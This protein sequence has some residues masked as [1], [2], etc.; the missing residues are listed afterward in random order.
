MQPPRAIGEASL[1]NRNDAPS[2]HSMF[3][4]LQKKLATDLQ[5][6]R[7]VI[8]HGPTL[9]DVSEFQWIEM[10]RNLPQRYAVTK[11]FV[12]DSTGA[13][14]GQQDIVIFDRHFSPLLFSVEGATFIPAESVYAVLEAKQKL[15]APDIKYAGEKAASVRGL[16]RTSVAITHAGGT[17]PPRE[18]FPILAGIVA[19]ESSWKQPLGP[20]LEKAL[21]SLESAERLDIGCAITGGSFDAQYNQDGLESLE[22]SSAENALIFFFI[23]LLHRL[24]QLGSVPAMDLVEYGKSIK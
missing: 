20:A 13:T 11:A 10:L 16:H 9:G 24:Q 22:R 7:T 19:L 18:P 2:L 15:T 17:F 5:A 14:S 3:A 12:V 8:R 4:E 6:G 23:R 1:V 21:A